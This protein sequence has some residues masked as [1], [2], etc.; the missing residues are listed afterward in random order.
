[1]LNKEETEA[2]AKLPAIFV[3]KVT[4]SIGSL[5][6][7]TFIEQQGQGGKM[8]PRSSIAIDKANAKE[9]C[10][11]LLKLLDQQSPIIQLPRNNSR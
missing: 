11:L 3:N 7:I 10:K 6:R 5:V 1:M 8:F 2:I 4:I 9:F